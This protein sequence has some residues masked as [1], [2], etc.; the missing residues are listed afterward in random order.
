M[1]TFKC[2]LFSL[3][4]VRGAESLLKLRYCCFLAPGW[5]LLDLVI[6]D[7]KITHTLL[8]CTLTTICLLFKSLL[9]HFYSIKHLRIIHEHSKHL[10]DSIFMLLKIYYH[11]FVAECS[12]TTVT[13]CVLRDM[14]NLLSCKFSPFFNLLSFVFNYERGRINKSTLASNS[15]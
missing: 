1:M 2:V 13:L 11:L 12:S 14:C 8:C 9:F 7:H 4:Y 15:P 10:C 5:T 6:V 3:Y